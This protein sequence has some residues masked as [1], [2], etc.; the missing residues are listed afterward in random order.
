M[1]CAV[2]WPQCVN[3]QRAVDTPQLKEKDKAERQVNKEQNQ[4]AQSANVQINGATA[5]KEEELRTQ[6]KEQI[7]AI[8]EL[9]LTAAR[10]DDAAFFLELFYRKNGYEKVEVRYS[11]SGGRLRLDI[12]EGAR[13]TLANINF[14]GNDNIDS[15]KLFE[16]VVG[17][18]RERYG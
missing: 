8:A 12:D 4:I 15:E 16:F 6:L 14:V 13:I 18:T 1:I 7:A 11:I 9:G 3:A 2:I 17:P 5:F 10:A